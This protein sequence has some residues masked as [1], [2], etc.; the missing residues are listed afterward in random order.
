MKDSY[1][2]PVILDKSEK[3]FINIIFPDFDDAVTCV[4]EGEDPVFEAQSWL[5]VN[6]CELID[7][8][9]KVPAPSEAQEIKTGKEQTLVFVNVWLP[10]HRTC[11]KIVY[12]KKTL[13]IPAYLDVLAKEADINFSETLADALKEK[14]GIS[15]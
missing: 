8:G 10:Y 14:L 12:V 9:E 15:R 11:E 5:A 1:T 2:Y 6:L 7:E 4:N 3:G 13:T